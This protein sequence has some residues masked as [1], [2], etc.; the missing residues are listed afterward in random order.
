MAGPVLLTGGSGFVGGAILERL[1]A[2]G[3]GWWTWTAVAGI[4]GGLLGLL[5]IRRRR[6]GASRA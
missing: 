2:D 4:A 3:R 1:V 6:G 5:Y